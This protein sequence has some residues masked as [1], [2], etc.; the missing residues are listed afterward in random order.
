MPYCPKCK[1]KYVEGK[2]IC[3]DCECELVDKLDDDAKLSETTFINDN[4]GKDFISNSGKQ[5]ITKSDKYKDLHSSSLSL[6]IVGVLGD[7]FLVLNTL[8]LLPIHFAFEGLSGILFYV[9][10]GT[11]LNVFLIG[12]IISLKSAVKIK[13]EIQSEEDFTHSVI[14]YIIDT[15]TKD[16][17]D[18]NFSLTDEASL[19]FERESF[20]KKAIS[21]KFGELDEA[22]LDKLIEDI[23]QQIFE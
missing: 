14:N 2:T 23:Y 20:I 15:Y 4:S 21:D 1:Y 5:Y 8:G 13:G 9:V 10:M 17:I 18:E 22:Y 11:L 19:Y 3:P 16:S 6:I 12:G 7:I